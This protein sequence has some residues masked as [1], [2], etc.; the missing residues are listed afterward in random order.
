MMK[1]AILGSG[2]MGCLYGG[3]L[4][5]AGNDVVLVDVWKEHMD[6]VNGSG[7]KIEDSNGE[8]TV[9]NIRGVTDPTAAGPVD[10]VIVFV[11][12]TATE[13]AMRGAL[14]LVGENTTVL[15]LQN[16]LGNV[17]KICGVVG[18]PRV[19][20]GTTG[21]GSTLVGPG[22]IR[23]AGVGET[24][25]GAPNTSE[26]SDGRVESLAS[27][28][29]GAKLTTRISKNVMGLIWTKL[30]VNVAINA[31]TAV[32]GLKNGRLV[33]FPETAE[34]M[35]LSVEEACAV[36]K[37]KGIRFDVDDPLEHAR[38]IAR[39]TAANRSSMLQDVM[40]KRPTE[41]SVINGAIVEE[42]KKLGIPTPV[43]AVLTNLVLTK[44]K[45]YEEIA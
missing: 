44:Q 11:K 9:K 16:G 33:D 12:A 36:A 28:F 7:L 42:G 32:T 26:S 23:H 17:E 38:N 2:A 25:I 41:V 45:T 19:V 13:Q 31:L 6:A 20:A 22:K 10:L 21:H 29:G 39:L 4:A 5:E 1:T 8:R 18:A 15:T 14:C 30:V 34:L 40:S 35:K 27:F 3:M 37:A 43:N 24:V